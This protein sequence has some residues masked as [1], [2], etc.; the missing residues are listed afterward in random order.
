[1]SNPLIRCFFISII[2]LS[3]VCGS[4]I[5]QEDLS[6]GASDVTLIKIALSPTGEAVWTVELKYP[7]TTPSEVQSF[8][9]L[10]ATFKSN[11]QSF[12]SLSPFTHAITVASA[13]T[14]RD[15]ELKEISYS[16]SMSDYHGSL[17]LSFVWT[18]FTYSQANTMSVGDVFSVESGEAWMPLLLENQELIIEFPPNYV[19]QSS[20]HSI[21]NGTLHV[22]GP[23]EFSP[24]EP[25]ATLIEFSPATPTISKTTPLSFTFIIAIL[26]S[27]S[28]GLLWILKRNFNWS[29]LSI[30]F[31]VFP[32][33]S[34]YPILRKYAPLPPP[35][36]NIPSRPINREPLISDEERVLTIVQ[37]HGGRIK[38]VD[39]VEKTD[40]SNAKVSQILSHLEAKG[41]IDKLR[42]GRE[43]LISL[44][45]NE[46]RD[47]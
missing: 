37:Q 18:N 40:W 23:A 47:R 21:Y 46:G 27:M 36:D 16:S 33:A 45:R 20:S 2:L 19:A 32:N 31:S 15:M 30:L 43:N 25:F 22:I 9:R 17:S 35:T 39:I 6:D 5:A 4:S 1:M 10:S 13:E 8:N 38:Q 41:F 28:I 44:R 12:I 34:R 24:G 14:G 7:L 42:I 26:L 3:A 29:L 11:G